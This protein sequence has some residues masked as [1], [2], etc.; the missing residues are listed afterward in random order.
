MNSLMETKFNDTFNKFKED[1]DK[2]ESLDIFVIYDFSKEE[3]E[4]KFTK[5]FKQ[6]DGISDTKKKGFL[7][8]RIFDFK[9]NIEMYKDDIINGIFFVGESIKYFELDKYYLETLKLF[10]VSKINFQFDKNYNIKWLKD[11]LLD[12]NYV[13]VLKVKNNDISLI[14]FT[15]TKQLSIYSDTQKSMN[16][17]EIINTKLIADKDSKFI[18]HG[19]SSHLKQLHDSGYKNKNCLGIILKELNLE[20]TID[21]IDKSIYEENIKELEVWLTKLLDPKEGHKLVFGNDIEESTEQGFIETIY[22]T[23]ENKEKYS[24]FENVNIKLVKSYK[25]GDSIYNYSKNYNGVLGIK[26]Y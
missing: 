19:S 21:T 15:S 3:M 7:K 1:K 20:E 2:F 6:L 10:K 22:C 24:K 8:S 17:L 9:K 23:P 12:R 5:I 16:L 11:L 25:N 26:Y 14:K 18:I 13:N 4:E